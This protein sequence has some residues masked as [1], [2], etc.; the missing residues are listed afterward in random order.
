MQSIAEVAGEAG[1][2]LEAVEK[3]KKLEPAILILDL[4]MPRLDGIGVLERIPGLRIRKPRVIVL[5]AIGHEGVI[6][7]AMSLGAERYLVKPFDME[8]LRDCI[9]E[10]AGAQTLDER[11]AGIFYA[12]GIPAKIKGYRYLREAVKMAVHD[13]SLTESLMNGLYPGIAAR[14]GTTAGNVQRDIQFAV[15]AAWARGDQ[16]NI[17]ALFGDD[18]AKPSNGKFIA[19][20]AGKLYA[21][22][23]ATE[24]K[25]E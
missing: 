25:E 19:L 16:E 2:G 9:A 1:D 24:K 8:A 10:I 21:R 17:N 22:G 23:N 20:V 13:P 3:L 6:R 11:I 7:E 5:S 18:G 4:I 15:N 12:I 14:F